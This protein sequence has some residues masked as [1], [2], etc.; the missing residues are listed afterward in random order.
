MF[1]EKKMFLESDKVHNLLYNLNINLIQ[2]RGFD[3]RYFKFLPVVLIGALLTG[4]SEHS[5]YIGDEVDVKA[6]TKLL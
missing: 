6:N 1:S 2:L 3:M 5:H 4:C